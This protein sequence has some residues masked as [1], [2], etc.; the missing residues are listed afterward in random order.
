MN[1]KLKNIIVYKN[2][3]DKFDIGH[4]WT[5]VKVMARLSN[6]S[7]S[8]AIQTIRY[9]NLTL[10]QAT[11]LI[12]SMYVYLILIYKFYKQRHA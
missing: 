12:L 4:R 10:V 5:K 7:P 8:T 6:F 9:H 11:K 3:S 2:I 1:M